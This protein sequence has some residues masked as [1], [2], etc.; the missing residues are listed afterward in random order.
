MVSP[1]LTTPRSKKETRW[2][3]PECRSREATEAVDLWIYMDLS[4]PWD[5]RGIGRLLVGVRASELWAISQVG[6]ARDSQR[7]SVQSDVA[8]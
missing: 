3:N 6:E 1:T 8:R 7:L 5:K 4:R 2:P